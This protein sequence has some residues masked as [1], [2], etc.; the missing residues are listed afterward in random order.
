M[1]AIAGRT[2]LWVVWRKG[3]T[4]GLTQYVVRQ[5]AN[6]VGLVDYKICAID[7]HWSGM[8]F[9]VKKASAVSER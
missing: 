4:N 6:D 5:S 2:K 8:A 9:A 1:K 7:E 3:S